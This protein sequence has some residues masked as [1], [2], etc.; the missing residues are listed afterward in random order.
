MFS[1]CLGLTQL[2]G[3][4]KNDEFMLGFVFGGIGVGQ[5]SICC[6]ELRKG[7]NSVVPRA[8]LVRSGCTMQ[9]SCTPCKTKT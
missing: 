7:D 1:A 8:L 5:K 4:T 6:W 9:A 3:G 2:L